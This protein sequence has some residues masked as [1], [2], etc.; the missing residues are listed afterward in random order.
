[1]L[2]LRES[3]WLGTV[4]L[5]VTD[6][7]AVAT[8]FVLYPNVERKCMMACPYRESHIIEVLV[9]V[10]IRAG[11]SLGEKSGRCGRCIVSN[12]EPTLTREKFN[13]LDFK[14]SKN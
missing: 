12:P 2:T 11:I 6:F 13:V 7:F 8:N 10:T 9:I 1:M 3:T 5:N 14:I 4:A